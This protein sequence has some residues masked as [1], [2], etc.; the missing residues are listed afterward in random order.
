MQ[1]KSNAEHNN[2]KDEHLVVN[3]YKPDQKQF[4]MF[5]AVF[6]QSN[7]YW[8]RVSEKMSDLEYE[9]WI[10]KYV[11]S[12]ANTIAEFDDEN[13]NSTNIKQDIE[14]I[15]ANKKLYCV[16]RQPESGKMVA[17]DNV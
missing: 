11:T 8:K 15:D 12:D 10:L 17:C 14:E 4:S 13:E 7:E 5:D 16:C 9:N 6:K 1:S 2:V 3:N